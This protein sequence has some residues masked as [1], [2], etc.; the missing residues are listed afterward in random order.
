MNLK[1]GLIAA[2]FA[3]VVVVA[4]L[5]WTRGTNPRAA[6]AAPVYGQPAQNVAPSAAADASGQAYQPPNATAQPNYGTQPNY[7]A[8]YTPQNYAPQP[9][10]AQTSYAPDYYAPPETYLSV[11]PRPVVVRPP[12]PEP[13]YASA[14]PPPAPESVVP[15]AARPAYAYGHARHHRSTRR[16]V[17]IVAGSAGVGAAIGAIAGGG[18]GAGIGALAGGAGGFVYDRLTRH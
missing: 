16:S 11:I 5:G 2:A 14:P 12:E 8:D 4:V 18:K 13:A 6:S 3:I 9:G 1:N 15:P 10:Y 7:G 17:E